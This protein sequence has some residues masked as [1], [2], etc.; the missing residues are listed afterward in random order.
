MKILVIIIIVYLIIRIFTRYFLPLFLT[1]YIKK[2][3]K[4]NFGDKWHNMYK[5]E[6]N[7]P[8]INIKPN[9]KTPLKSEK[10]DDN[11]EYVD[12]TEIK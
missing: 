11:S 12:F 5:D 4:K 3:M 8:K 9:R 6:S 1:Y 7:E 10:K 2:T